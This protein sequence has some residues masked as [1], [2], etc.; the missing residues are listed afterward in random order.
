MSLASLDSFGR[1][2]TGFEQFARTFCAVLPPISY[3]CRAA[4]R[5]I[6]VLEE[7]VASVERDPWSYA[8]K[9]L[10]AARQI[11]ANKRSGLPITTID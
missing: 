6:V 8:R 5:P 11:C 4:D 10:D 9:L 2:P 3:D 1:P 7:E